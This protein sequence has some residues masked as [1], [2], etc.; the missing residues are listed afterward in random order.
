MLSLGQDLALSWW[1]WWRYQLLE[2]LSIASAEKFV[3]GDGRE[4]LRAPGVSIT[5]R[6]RQAQDKSLFGSRYED[7][8]LI[9]CQNGSD[10]MPCVI[11]TRVN[12]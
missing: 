5:R 8:N 4:K 9:F 7:H 2:P 6:E 1:V 12:C 3:W 11:R 10:C